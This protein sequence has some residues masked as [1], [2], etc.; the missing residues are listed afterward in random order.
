MSANSRGTDLKSAGWDNCSRSRYVDTLRV[1]DAGG[2][3]RSN[4]APTW[5]RIRMVSSNAVAAFMSSMLRTHGAVQET[6][7]KKSALCG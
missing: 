6:G 4:A 3:T 5:A 7:R 1:R 2:A